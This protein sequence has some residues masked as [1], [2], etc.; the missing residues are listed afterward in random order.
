MH[1]DELLQVI[2]DASQTFIAYVDRE[3]RYRF[4][5]ASYRRRFSAAYDTIV[6]KL[7]S[8]VFGEA[9]YEVIRE[10]VETA[11]AG[12]VA[13]HESLVHLAD[14][15]SRWLRAR[16]VPHTSQDGQVAGFVVLATDVT[17]QKKAE[18]ALRLSEERFHK[19]FAHSNDGIF[20]IDP[21]EDKIL[22]VNP[23]ACSMLEYTREELLSIPIS[24]VHPDEMPRLREFVS[25]VLNAGS[26]W[27]DELTCLTKSR[28][29]LAAEISAS[30]FEFSGRTCVLALVRD[31]TERKQAERAL[32][33][34]EERLASVVGSA[35]DAIVTVDEM[36]TI[37]LFNSA[38]EDVFGCGAAEI[39]GQSF[40][41]LTSESLREMLIGS[42]KDFAKAASGKR[43]LWAPEGLA[44]LRM[45]G[46]AFPI[47]A[48]ISRAEAGGERLFTII[49]R[50]VNDRR[51]AE[52]RLRRLEVQNVY[53]REEA[54]IESELGD[55]VGTSSGIR[56]VFESVDQVAAT[57][58][59]VLITG[60]TGTGKELVAKA[61]HERSNRKDSILVKVNCAAL[62]TGLVESELFGHEKGAFTGAIDRKIGR[63]ELA[64]GATLFL[65]EIGDLPLELQVKL[66]RVL[67]DGQFE[68]VGGTETLKVD[69]RLIAATNRDLTREVKEQ[70]FR[71]DLF[72][73]LNVF[74]I[75]VP[76]LRERAEDI[77]ALVSHLAMHHAL[78]MGKKIEMV[79]K[80]TL[81]S[82]VAYPWPGNVRELQNVIERGVILSR[83][84]E[85]ELGEWLPHPAST[86]DGS[87]IATLQELERNHILEVLESTDWRVSGKRGAARILDINPTTLEA[88]MKKLGIARPT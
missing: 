25:S 2:T 18:E 39:I 63:F 83:G 59:T 81:K 27:T 21:T 79:P 22:D 30:A 9:G 75:S 65:D 13:E 84:P 82:L 36:L 14:G 34:S 37:R 38:A 85:L 58:S 48:T 32:R 26:G 47:E 71:A 29:T 61:I 43:Y 77:P 23:T 19:V 62:P 76:P 51:Q 24:A 86:P 88:R 44:A 64:D 31:V 15:T 42:V 54:E 46:E 40:D 57:D 52:E 1:A 73:R 10:H 50:D 3:Q 69:V 8:E 78:R 12:K 53:L 72:Y 35:M 66:L 16:L 45:D 67:Q 5:N 87:R 55:I 68:R 49:L 41:R 4:V 80:A 70:R 60:E 20:V 74:P 56:R 28:R 17:E 6:G 7:V 11:L 33:E